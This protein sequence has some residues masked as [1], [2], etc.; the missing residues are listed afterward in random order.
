M[1]HE[2]W[3]EKSPSFLRNRVEERYIFYSSPSLF[4]CPHFGFSKPA[5]F[6]FPEL[7]PSHVVTT[8]CQFFTESGATFRTYKEATNIE[9]I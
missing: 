1:L 6:L 4:L 7:S 5:Q 2:G 8:F 3:R 9:A